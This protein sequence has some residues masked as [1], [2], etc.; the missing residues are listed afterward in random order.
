MKQ[1]ELTVK[2]RA[3]LD[4]LRAARAAGV[5]LSAYA[6]ERGLEPRPLH[7]AV[8]GLRRRGVLPPTERSR[9]RKGAFVA[10]RVVERPSA[11]LPA[12]ARAGLVCRLVH[13]GGFVIECAEW[14]PAA[15]LMSLTGLRD[16]A[17]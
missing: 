16:A 17:P 6:R 4:A 2:Q 1:R 12:A 8:A 14:P 7:D 5:G 13:S 3:G 10:V 9:P 15:W 11:I